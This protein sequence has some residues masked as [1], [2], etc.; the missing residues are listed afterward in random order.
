MPHP[1]IS[2]TRRAFTLIELLV[3]IAII[4]I[5]ASI[6]F[7]VFGR[8]RENARRSSCQSNLKQ[9]GL[10]MIQYTADYDNYLPATQ[11]MEGTI[12]KTWATLT[13]PY[14][15]SG[16]LYACPSGE[17]PSIDPDTQFIDPAVGSGRTA[18]C[19][20][21]AGDG[22][23]SGV[24]A[25]SGNFISYTRNA[26]PNTSASWS[27]TGFYGTG[28]KQGFIATGPSVPLN[29]SVIEDPAGTIHI[30]DGLSGAATA[31][32]TATACNAS[33][34][35]RIIN[36]KSTDHFKDSETSKPAYRH[37]QGFNAL[38]GDGHVK[39]RRYGSTKAGEW[40][41]QPND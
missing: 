1:L 8:A 27:T 20:L 24:T 4:A 15:K 36:E 38:Y 23:G 10:A 7:P 21:S 18:Y 14:V 13:S 33:S 12:T 6:L 16:Q 41:V 37:F 26:I 28:P 32:G 39:W 30:F 5:L 3:V 9:I 22:S 2:R 17:R 34:S 40:S 19:G 25:L 29:E 31:S 35:I 11:A